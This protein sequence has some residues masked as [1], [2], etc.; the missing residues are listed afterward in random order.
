MQQK[1]FLA[2]VH[3]SQTDHNIN[4]HSSCCKKEAPKRQEK[5]SSNMTVVR[6]KPVQGDGSEHVCTYMIMKMYA[7][8]AAQS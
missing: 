5:Q 3:M 6:E 2:G 7:W 8:P 1:V 4:P